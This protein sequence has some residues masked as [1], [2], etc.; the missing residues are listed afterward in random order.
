[1]KNLILI[2]F[3]LVTFIGFSQTT[4][5]PDSNFEQ[6]LIDDG[7]D[8]DGTVNGTVLTSDISGITSLGLSNMNIFDLT[9]ISDFTSLIDLS[10]D[11]NRLTSLDV[12]LNTSLRELRC[13]FNSLTSLDLSKN[14][15]LEILFYDS[16]QIAS[17]DLSQNTALEYL[18]CHGNQIAS[19]DLSHNTNLLELSCGDNQLISLDLSQNTNIVEL[20]CGKNQLTSLDVSNNAALKILDCEENQLTSFDV[21]NNTALWYLKCDNNQLTSLDV[22]LNTTLRELYV[23]NN[24]LTSLD[25]SLNTSLELLYCQYNNLR[26][27]NVKNGYNNFL[28]NFSAQNNPNL[29]CIQV[30][31][32]QNAN[33]RTDN[34]EGWYK[35]TQS[36]YSE[37]PCNDI[38]LTSDINDVTEDNKTAVVTAIINSGIPAGVDITINISTSGT[39]NPTDYELSSN[40]III[41]SGQLSGSVT[42]T[43]KDEAFDS[44]KT[45][46]IDI[47]SIT[48][49]NEI[50]EQ[51]VIITIIE[52]SIIITGVVTNNY[53]ST[54]DVSFIDTTIEGHTDPLSYQ[55]SSGETTENIS[56]K[57]DGTYTLTVTDSKN[58]VKS[59]EFIIESE[60]IYSDLSICYVTSD[61]GSPDNNRIYISNT[62]V[63]NVDKMQVL[64]EGNVAGYYDVLT[65]LDP[66]VS[67]YLDVSSNNQEVSYNYTVRI[68]DKC[69]NIS[70]T[71]TLHKTVLLQANKAANGSI[72][73][74]WSEYRGLSYGTYDIYRSVNNGNFE[75][76]TSLSSNNLGYNDTSANADTNSYNYYIGITLDSS[77]NFITN[78]ANKSSMA[79]EIIK[80]NIKVISSTLGVDDEILDNS[81]KFYPNPTS[82]ILSIKSEIIPI[83]KIEIYSILGK[84][85]KEI[86]S[87]FDSISTDYLSKDIYIIRI[88]S[89]KGSIVRKLI[90]Q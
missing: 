44:E 16:N 11:N 47:D 32:A 76:L 73:L 59:K 13:G 41:P 25:V 51:Q 42:L 61:D 50:E 3:V 68:K 81:I 58:M 82:N 38:K 37:E 55:W 12:S 71:S 77:C 6:A 57:P 27:L 8:S 24:Q 23:R 33:D 5:I 89:E 9:G 14:T 30:D 34:N 84:K 7:I 21:S 88:Y 75:L 49:G 78:S 69:G 26:S 4:S 67:S 53:C 72:N 65:E 36:I 86:N 1:M 45:I 17:L 48:N 62:G 66:N 31:N 64:R 85:I 19:L 40:T 39:A 80:S 22:S 18:S 46:I 29:L 90:K 20:L 10:C 43:V 79:N 54:G 70:E 63:Y 35:D 52:N 2:T 74:N 28:Y 83:D 87:G 15:A 60:P 56:N